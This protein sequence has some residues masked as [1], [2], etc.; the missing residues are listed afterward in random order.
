MAKRLAN[1]SLLPVLK[2][3]TLAG[4]RKGPPQEVGSRFTRLSFRDGSGGAAILSRV[5]RGWLPAF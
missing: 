3:L 5:G 1:H 2:S 4:R